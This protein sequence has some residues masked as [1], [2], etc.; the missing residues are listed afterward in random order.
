MRSDSAQ[1]ARKEFFLRTPVSFLKNS[2]LTMDARALFLVLDAYADVRTRETYVQ[3]PTLRKVTGWGRAKLE[4][5]LRE[6]KNHSLI[7]VFFVRMRGRFRRRTCR[8]KR[9]CPAAHS[10]VSGSTDSGKSSKPVSCTKELDH[11]PASGAFVRSGQSPSQISTPNTV[12][13]KSSNGEFHP[14]GLLT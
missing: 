1:R 2:S 11:L 4:R 3:A 8:L 10:T 7:E 6:L 12:A 13:Q 14:Q 5:V 9:L